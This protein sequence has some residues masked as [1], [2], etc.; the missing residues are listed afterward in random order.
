M[1]FNNNWDQGG[2]NFKDRFD[3]DTV[4]ENAGWI[5]NYYHGSKK[6]ASTKYEKTEK[7]AREHLLNTSMI[8]SLW[9]CGLLQGPVH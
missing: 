6:L 2:S 5:C 4:K 3:I 7:E 9:R 8:S 1:A